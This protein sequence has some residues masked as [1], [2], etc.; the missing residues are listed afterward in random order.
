[1]SGI[2]GGGPGGRVMRLAGWV[3]AVSAAV[4]TAHGLTE[5]ALGSNVPSGIAWMYP[6]ITDGLGVLAYAATSRL[7]R[8]GRAYAWLVVVVAAGLSAGAQASY[9]ADGAAQASR[10]LRFAVGAWPAIAAAVAAHLLY[11]IGAA[12]AS[13]VDR[14]PRLDIPKTPEA[15]GASVAQLGV[16]PAEGRGVQ[17]VQLGG[18]QRAIGSV[19]QPVQPADPKDEPSNGHVPA[20][21]R[22]EGMRRAF[23][24]RDRAAVA[25]ELHLRQAGTLPTARQL[26]ALAQVSRGTAATAIKGLRASTQQPDEQADGE[27]PETTSRAH[28]DADT[29]GQEDNS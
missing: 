17:A 29:S 15:A 27:P 24:P 9:L 3:V 19:V 6:V 20:V 21:G 5:V 28:S 16:Q 10:L 8:G 26:A 1:M 2:S 7:G 22:D 11:L 12:H 25:A 23:S 13:L 18:V 4:L 14:T